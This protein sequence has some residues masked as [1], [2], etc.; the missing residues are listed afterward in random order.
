MR[1]IINKKKDGTV[2][3]DFRK[4]FSLYEAMLAEWKKKSKDFNLDVLSRIMEKI[5]NKETFAIDG[6]G[7]SKPERWNYYVEWMSK[8]LKKLDNKQCVCEQLIQ[9]I[10]PIISQEK[11]DTVKLYDARVCLDDGGKGPSIDLK[12]DIDPLTK[13]RIYFSICAAEEGESFTDNI[14]RCPFC[15]R[16]LDNLTVDDFK[17][18]EGIDDLPF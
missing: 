14:K 6:K 5:W 9:A 1:E 7:R 12:A 11:I 4:Y 10:R 13:K 3:Y 18:L 2:E 8:E 15:G 16:S 17:P